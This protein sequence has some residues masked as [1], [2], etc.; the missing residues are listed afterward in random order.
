M[1]FDEKHSPFVRDLLLDLR[2]AVRDLKR[3]NEWLWTQFVKDV[4]F[5]G[6]KLQIAQLQ[7]ENRE[8]CCNE[9]KRCCIANHGHKD[10]RWKRQ[11]Q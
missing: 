7:Q 11:L 10:E 9:G 2:D 4:D 8:G 1:W 6:L 3:E 5:D